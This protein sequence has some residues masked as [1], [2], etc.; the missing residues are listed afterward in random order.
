MPARDEN[1]GRRRG[2]DRGRPQ[3]SGAGPAGGRGPHGR[4]Q[5]AG[6]ARRTGP[7]NDAPW[8]FV[9]ARRLLEQGAVR[10]AMEQAG[11]G[12]R[13][14]TD[15]PEGFLILGEINLADGNLAEARRDFEAALKKAERRRALD[16]DGGDPRLRALLGLSQTA[17]LA[18][19]LATVVKHLVAAIRLDPSDPFVLGPMLAEAALLVSDHDLA[20][21]HVGAPDG[22]PPDQH[23]VAAL[24]HLRRGETA[25]AVLRTRLAF[26]GNLYLLAAFMGEE[27]PHHGIA[28]GFEEATP[29][30]AAEVADRLAALFA[31]DPELV[32][33]MA[34]VAA[35]RVV[36]EEIAE[37][38][39][40]AK[41]L[42]R[43]PDAVRRAA[44][45]ARAS[46]LRD[47]RRLEATT[48]SVLA[49][50]S[51]PD[52]PHEATPQFDV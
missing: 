13:L 38:V 7:T 11:F 34:A 36:Q 44:L 27:P 22:A 51:E 19:D 25:D 2:P 35:T 18:G 9:E 20:A 46:E 39:E 30:Y 16:S 4:R 41:R 45:I 24:I 23:A 47:P 32:D 28:H 8:H 40:I 14:E 5:D 17:R 48:P 42:S 33:A 52:D 12:I 6:S 29:E 37:F 50:L 21:R 3:R 49:E 26:F 1:R 43:E 31:A 15:D 10:A